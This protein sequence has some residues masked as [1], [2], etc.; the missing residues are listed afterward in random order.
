MV[1]Q[2]TFAE[3]WNGNRLEAQGGWGPDGKLCVDLGGEL[4]RRIFVGPNPR[5]ASNAEFM[6]AE[7]PDVTAAVG[8]HRAHAK[9]NGFSLGHVILRES[10][11]HK[12]PQKL[13]QTGISE[14]L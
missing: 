5:P 6:V 1:L 10:S 13:P 9:R 7:I 2:P 14:E 3:I 11:R 4:P 12:T 8:A